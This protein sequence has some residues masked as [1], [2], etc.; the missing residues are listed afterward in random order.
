MS[1]S[2]ISCRVNCYIFE[3][4]VLCI[5]DLSKISFISRS[6]SYILLCLFFFFRCLCSAPMCVHDLLYAWSIMLGKFVHRSMSGDESDG[7]VCMALMD[8]GI[9]RIFSSGNGGL[10]P[11]ISDVV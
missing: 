6:T 9:M 7:V 3:T 10:L 8:L 1:S 4:G 5:Y 2:T 11:Y